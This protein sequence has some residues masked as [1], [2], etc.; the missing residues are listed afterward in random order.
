M[1][2]QD[3]IG[4]ISTVDVRVWDAAAALKR[5]KAKTLPVTDI[6]FNIHRFAATALIPCCAT[7]GRYQSALNI[8]RMRLLL[9]EKLTPV[10]KGPSVT[11]GI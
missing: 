1:L 11:V 2:I 8:P 9:Q 4:P 5:L 10:I 3:T 7:D 6:L